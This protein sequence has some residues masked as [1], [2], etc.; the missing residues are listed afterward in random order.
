MYRA[1]VTGGGPLAALLLAAVLSIAGCGGGED[2]LP[3]FEGSAISDKSYV[4]N[5]AIA[6]ETLPAASGGDG[7]LTYAVSP[8]LPDGLVFDPVTR[9]LS[10]TPAA[11]QPATLYTYT[12]T[13]GDAVEPDTA[14]LTFTLTVHEDL[15]PAF[16]RAAIPDRTYERGLAIAGETLPAASGGDGTLTYTVSPALPDGLVFDP[17]TRRLS[18]TP[19]AAQPATLY[20]Y[21]A[22]DGDA[23]EPDTA[24]LTFTLTVH[25]DLV[26]VFQQVGIADRTYERG[27]A[28]AGE[29][30][31]AAS[32]GDGA[33]TYAL[34]PALPAGLIFDPLTR[35]LSGTPAAAHPAT[36]Y[37][38]TAT[39]GD[40]VE[41]D[42]AALTFSITVEATATVTISTAAEEADEGDDR[43]PVTVTLT[44]SEPVL[45]D[46]AIAL[47]STGT[48]L[49]GSD[50]DLPGTEVIVPAGATRATTTITP[51]RD[52]EAEGDETVRLEIDSIAGRG[53]VGATSSIDVVIRDLGGP[54]EGDYASFLAFFTTF[55]AIEEDAVTLTFVVFNNGAA[56]ASPTQ[57]FVLTVAPGVSQ[58]AL[59]SLPV[60]ALEPKD[61]FLGSV[62][63]PF[64]ELVPGVN[65]F[66]I[67]RVAPVPE[68]DPALLAADEG[69]AVRYE[70]VFLT[71][72]SRIPTACAGFVR[73]TD[74]GTPDPL[75]GQQWALDNTGQTS[76]AAEGGV[77]GHD[78]NMRQAQAD[79][80]TGAGVRVAVV[81]TKVPARFL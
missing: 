41:P 56:G 42:T 18:G 50:F 80:L 46:V 7:T 49:L 71:D 79:G 16:E 14:T 2:R 6:G 10:G 77:A 64:D 52:L 62:R 23:V 9:R 72:E 27:L 39:D 47:R 48:A 3:T 63:V 53:E 17:V 30:L 43:T 54:P 55:D 45:G 70:A 5:L 33:L 76:F 81:D 60:P 34:S 51:I 68:E 29:T 8:E 78:L 75:S 24:T 69:G 35:R 57:A 25:E 44:L 36:L 31:P 15:M 1:S 21:T 32:G 66:F 22:T 19:A 11:A 37:V 26:P 65:N 58:A 67:L 74:P 59:A 20:I 28:I 38:Y 40:A 4:Q 73:D 13:D 12:A 61:G